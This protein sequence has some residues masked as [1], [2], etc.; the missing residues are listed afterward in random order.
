MRLAGRPRRL[1]RQLHGAA[2]LEPRPRFLACERDGALNPRQRKARAVAERKTECSRDA[3]QRSGQARLRP[4]EWDHFQ[5]QSV[6]KRIDR[7]V[8]EPG[9]S[10]F[11]DDFRKIDRAYL[12]VG[13]RP[14]DPVG[15]P[16]GLKQT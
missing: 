14:R 11:A 1:S 3:A 8:I 4:I 10:E 9:L 16:F 13:Q 2:C 12:S 7:P 6:D 15:A 5:L